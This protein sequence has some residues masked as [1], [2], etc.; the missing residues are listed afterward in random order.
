MIDDGSTDNTSI[1]INNIKDE[2]I[3]YIKLESNKGASYARNVGI[4]RATGDYITFQDSDDIY[5]YD[6]IEK[7]I[8]NIIKN[9]S[10]FDFCK[11]NVILENK[12]IVIFP[13]SYQ[14]KEI[15][16]GNTYNELLKNGNFISTQSIF[17]KNSFIK[18]CT[19]DI[20]MPRLQD[21]E[22]VLRILPIPKPLRIC[23]R[24][25]WLPSISTVL[26]CP[27]CQPISEWNSWAKRSTD[28]IF[29]KSTTLSLSRPIH[30]ICLSPSCR[31]WMVR[32]RVPTDVNLSSSA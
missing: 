3:K 26:R 25:V 17:V 24:V 22:L 16:K 23:M 1:V 11:I 29:R 14:E 13:N 2:R 12:Q 15:L 4:E 30:R 32:P 5:H 9:K 27:A 28:R 8:N 6:K 19:F 10:D 7:Q 21:Y 20:D 31:R 18:N